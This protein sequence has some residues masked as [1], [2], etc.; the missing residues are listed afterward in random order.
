LQAASPLGLLARGY[1]LVRDS[2]GHPVT[3]AAGQQPDAR[4]GL[5]F[6]DGELLVRVE[7]AGPA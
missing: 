5:R 2:D 4:L 6:A 1:A 7:D 3:Q